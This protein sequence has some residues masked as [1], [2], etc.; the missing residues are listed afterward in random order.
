MVSDIAEFYYDVEEYSLN[1][2]CNGIWSRTHTNKLFFVCG[3]KS[4]NPCCNG[5]WSRTQHVSLSSVRMRLNPCCN[6]IWSRTI[7][8]TVP[9]S[10]VVVLILVVMEYGLGHNTANNERGVTLES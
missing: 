2:C 10:K 4:L 6:G 8:S 9:P 7:H 3:S 1:P 5:I